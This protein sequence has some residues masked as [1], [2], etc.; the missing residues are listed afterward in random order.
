M[1]HV[2]VNSNYASFTESSKAL[3]EMY[4]IY[5]KGKTSW[6]FPKTDLHHAVLGKEMDGGIAWIGTLC[7]PTDGFGLTANVQGNYSEMTSAVNW[8]FSTVSIGCVHYVFAC[9][10]CIKVRTH[11][12]SSFFVSSSSSLHSFSKLWFVCFLSS[13]MKLDTALVRITLMRK[14]P[15]RHL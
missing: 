11:S 4:D 7:S 15:T 5:G 1:L 13:C 12:G 9:T 10:I 14:A 6:H 2:D 3:D 8:D